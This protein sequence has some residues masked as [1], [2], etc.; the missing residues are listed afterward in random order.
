MTPD[1]SLRL[2]SVVVFLG[3]IAAAAWA[4]AAMLIP[5]GDFGAQIV[6][7]QLGSPWTGNGTRTVTAGAQSPFTNVFADNGKGVNTPE[8]ANSYF[9]G[10]IPPAG[11]SPSDPYYN[12]IP[13][14]AAGLLYFNADFQNTSAATGDYTLVVT[15]AQSGALRTSALYI[16]GGA[17]Y[18]ESNSGVT[19]VM[20][21]AQDTWYNVQ[22]TLDLT[23]NTYSGRVTPYGG[24]STAI[25][26][27]TFITEN[28]INCIYTDGGGPQGGSP[29]APNHDIDNFTLSTT[30]PDAR[31]VNIDFN[32]V[33]NVPGPDVPGPTYSGAGAAGGGNVF[34]GILADSRLTYPNDNDNLTVGGIY[35]LDSYGIA[36]GAG[37]TVSPVGG[38]V[39][40]T[41]TTDPTSYQAL[42]GDYVFD[43]SAGNSSD[44]PFVIS[45]LVGAQADLY[46]YFTN[47]ADKVT[48]DGAAPGTLVPS[49]IFNSGNTVYFPMVPIVNGQITGHFGNGT[50]VIEGLTIVAEAPV[51]EPGSWLLLALGGLGLLCRFR[52]PAARAGRADA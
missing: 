33:R 52:R 31:I 25:P 20:S 21:L 19:N 12:V 11:P 4:P 10:W 36:T 42:F 45:G 49:S 23:G 9:I 46:F 1:R 7:N 29:A 47:G 3:A 24:T 38:D 41:P 30:S 13:A 50:A 5:D 15:K 51:P 6:G 35:L 14:N 18:A 16:T 39:G 43:H 26:T 32:G 8:G 48:V 2:V 28:G 17:L 27:Q 22:L 44:S 37:F 40:G 34:N